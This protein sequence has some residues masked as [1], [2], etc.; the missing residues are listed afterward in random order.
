MCICEIEPTVNLICT[1]NGSEVF[2]EIGVSFIVLSSINKHLEGWFE[3]VC[4]LVL[5]GKP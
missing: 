4:V 5:L 3:A 2:C 1:D